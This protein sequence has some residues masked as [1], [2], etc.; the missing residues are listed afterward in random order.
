MDEEMCLVD[1]YTT[2]TIHRK[3]KYFQTLTKRMGNILTIAGHDVCIV[4]SR[5]ATIILSMGTQV[6]IENALFYPDAT[7]TLLSYRDIHK[8]RLHI[9]TYEKNN[10]ESLLITKSNGDG[11]DIL[12]RIPSLP[13]ELYY[14]HIKLVPQVVY[15]VI[16]QNIYAFQIGHDRLEHPSVGMM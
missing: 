11:Y 3:T 16:F 13:S 14:T 15:K 10:E 9:V 8:N 6:T 4:G 5:K 12:E 7:H 1:N 2:N